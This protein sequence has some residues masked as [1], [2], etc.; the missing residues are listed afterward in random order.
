MGVPSP[1]SSMTRPTFFAR[2]PVPGKLPGTRQ[3]QEEP[4]E[5]AEAAEPGTSDARCGVRARARVRGGVWR[6]SMHGASHMPTPGLSALRSLVQRLRLRRWRW[7]RVTTARHKEQPV[8][9]R[10]PPADSDLFM[11]A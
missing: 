9:R 2:T 3:Q 8:S 7:C 1:W 5:A 6:G 4:P 10:K 11:G